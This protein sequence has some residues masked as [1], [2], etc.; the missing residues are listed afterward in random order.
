MQNIKNTIK[1]RLN[2]TPN[3]LR[4]GMAIMSLVALVLGGS[5]S[6]HWD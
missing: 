2:L 3:H 1:N 6:G 5:A 4:L